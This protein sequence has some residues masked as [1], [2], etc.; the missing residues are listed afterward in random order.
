MT[1]PFLSFNRHLLAENTLSARQRE[2]VILRVAHLRHCGYEWAQHT[3]LAERAG[4]A[5]EEIARVAHGALRDWSTGER[6]L[7][8][9]TDELLA[10]GTIG[11][12]TWHVLVGEFDDEQLMDLVFTVGTYALVAMALRSFGVEPETELLPHLPNGH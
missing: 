9:A 8:V 1:K 12:D 3:I 6:A 10:D 5:P 4:I 7:L 11:E 2:L